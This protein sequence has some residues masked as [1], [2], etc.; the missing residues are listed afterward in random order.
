[1][2]RSPSQSGW[3]DATVN[4]PLK[5]CLKDNP[6]IQHLQSE[7]KEDV[8]DWHNK[9]G[10]SCDDC[11]LTKFCMTLDMFDAMLSSDITDFKLHP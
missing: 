4:D 11:F 9:G 8:I 3:T 6:A 10:C 7:A 2:R 1:M 5:M